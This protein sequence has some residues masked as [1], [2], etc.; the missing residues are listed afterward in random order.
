MAA[1]GSK[2]TTDQSRAYGCLALAGIVGAIWLVSLLGGA[3]PEISAMVP[4]DHFAMII[5]SGVSAVDAEALAREKC[6]E[7]RWCKVLGWTDKSNAARTLPMLDRE[8][9]SI[10]FS[11][12]VNRPSGIEELRWDCKRFPQKSPGLCLAE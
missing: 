1:N 3:K 5:P 11:Y 6:S 12:F 2:M 8:A 9:R 7:R 4:P 10:A